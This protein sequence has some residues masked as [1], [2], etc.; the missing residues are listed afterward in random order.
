M[1]L[2]AERGVP[3]RLTMLLGLAVTAAVVVLGMLDRARLDAGTDT[4]TRADLTW[5]VVAAAGVLLIWVAGMT[6]QLG[7]MTHRPPL[8]RL[9]LVQIAGSFA[10]H[11]LP[12]GA[13]G[14]AINLRFLRRQGLSRQ[15]AVASQALNHAAGVAAHLVLFTGA[16]LLAPKVVHDAH[17]G[18]LQPRLSLD[19]AILIS[20]LIGA[21]FLAVAGAAWLW[22]RRSGPTARPRRIPLLDGLRS[23]LPSLAGILR[24]PACGLQLWLGSFIT[25]L[26][27]AGM[28]VA[29]VQALSIPLPVTTV[30]AIYL[31]ASTL[32]GLIPSPGGLGALDVTLTGGLIA[33]GASAGLALGA[34]MAYR[35]ITV[36]LPLIPGALVLGFLVRRR[37][38]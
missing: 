24:S 11:L 4:L 6:T 23:E 22:R 30:V 25:P 31:V 1:A 34:V 13:G 12:A 35:L 33:G 10:N 27:H 16:L 38:I 28:L 29:V 7:A 20:L 36:W 17:A 19:H 5:L 18:S 8:G 26:L 15:S 14:L 37:I 32:S 9:F 21:A 3:A 2:P